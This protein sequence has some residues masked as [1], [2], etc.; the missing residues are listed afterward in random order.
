MFRYDDPITALAAADGVKYGKHIS[1]ITSED[2][3]VTATFEDGTTATGTLIVGC[4]GANS[5][6]RRFLVGEEA[7]KNTYMDVQML[8]VSCHF[9]AETAEYLRSIHPIFKTS[10]HPDG[11]HWWNSIQDVPDPDKPETWSFQNLLSW[12]GAPRAEDLPDQASRIQFWR[13]RGPK[14]AEPFKTIGAQLPDDLVFPVDST[15]VW[16]PDFDWSSSPLWPNVTIAGDAAHAIPPFRGQGLNNALQDAAGLVDWLKEV[17]DGK[18]LSEAV[19]GYEAE[20]KERTLTELK[21]SILQAETVH[22]WE[23]LMEAP[24]VKIGM[25]KF[26]EQEAKA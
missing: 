22:N 26:K 4:D 8:N 7:A 6:V 1:S 5:S 15:A 17:V 19:A 10:Y 13:E 21:V 14:A 11:F 24:F 9:P 25:N 18:D 2:R 3:S 12:S 23:R 20:M 16:K